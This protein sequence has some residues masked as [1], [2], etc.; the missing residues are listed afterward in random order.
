M[1]HDQLAQ[2]AQRIADG[3][4]TAADISLYNEL[5]SNVEAGEG[6][7]EGELGDRM[8]TEKLLRRRIY[9]HAGIRRNLLRSVLVKTS[10][11]AAVAVLVVFTGIKFWKTGSRQT[12]SDKLLT[13]KAMV[14]GSNRAVLTLSNGESVVL[15][16]AGNRV[17]QRG[18]ATIH[19]R[20]GEV[21]YN[22]TTS[23]QQAFN[24]LTTPA[25]GQ[26]Q[27]V[28]PDGTKVWLNAASSLR[29]PAGF[30]G[31]E[32]RVELSGEAYFEVAQDTKMPFVVQSGDKQVQV[33]GTHFNLMA[34]Q[35]EP[36]TDVTLLEGV[37]KVIHRADT[38]L[39]KPGQQAK[40]AD[41]RRIQLVPHADTEK[42]IAW[43]NG[44]FS[45]NGE[46]TEVVMRQLARWY[47][48]E[49][50]YA[51]KVPD[52]KFEGSIKRSYELA[53]V[54]AILEESGIHFK[55]DGRKIIV[56]PA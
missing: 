13:G 15:D 19:L 50:V 28:L 1:N 27:L 4:A 37:V 5:L 2:L 30:D 53:D 25:G 40:L 24:V 26:Y 48:A 39:L 20:N 33:L 54:L 14:P 23:Q 32:R 43:K 3:T 8:A 38:A 10:V 21:V 56:L 16:S 11:A 55:I 42:I 52:L 6:W 41:A 49:I 36:S 45:L 44:F 31:K 35:E 46:G 47:N 12:D 7:D 9:Q 17:M 34:Y 22:N 29:F 51:G 18:S